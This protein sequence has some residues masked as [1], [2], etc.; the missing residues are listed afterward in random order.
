VRIDHCWQQEVAWRFRQARRAETC[1]DA[2]RRLEVERLAVDLPKRPALIVS[3]L[4]Q[5]L[6][7]C[8]WLLAGWRVLAD[9]LRGLDG[10]VPTVALDEEGRRMACDLLGLAPERRLART[11]FDPPAG[12]G[13]DAETAAHQAALIDRQIA[14]LEQLRA[15]RVDLDEIEQAAAELGCGTGVDPTLR[16]IRRYESEGHRRM[17]QAMDELRRLKS[18]PQPRECSLSRSFPE[19]RLVDASLA[20]TSSSTGPRTCAARDRPADIAPTGLG[21]AVA[22]VEDAATPTASGPISV[23]HPADVDE[24]AVTEEDHRTEGVR[25]VAVPEPDACAIVRPLTA[26]SAVPAT[27]PSRPHSLAATFAPAVP[28]NRRA[29]RALERRSAHRS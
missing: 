20:A 2:D 4:R 19:E 9:A 26:T 25:A 10:G 23:L 22:K 14:R 17:R 21:E 15:E 1:W 6:Q 11:P 7:G 24:P 28:R 12:S 3:Q 29:R 27:V 8:D 5:T 18:G 16:L 13:G